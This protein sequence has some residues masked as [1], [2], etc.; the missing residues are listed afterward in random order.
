MRDKKLTVVIRGKLPSSKELLGFK[1]YFPSH[2]SARS[3]SDSFRCSCSLPTSLFHS[4]SQLSLSMLS[5]PWETRNGKTTAE[6]KGMDPRRRQKTQHLKTE[7]PN[8]SWRKIVQLGKLDRD[9]KSCSHRWRNYLHPDINKGEFSQEEDE[10]I[11]FLKGADVR[12]ASMPKYV[13]R[14][15]ANAI[16]NRWNNHLKKKNAT[17]D[18]LAYL[19]PNLD[20]NAIRLIAGPN[21]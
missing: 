6:E 10:L 12:W 11:I 18:D 21:S 14:R 17:I 16:K 20:P 3:P 15:S 4:F 2:E 1:L 9:E 7:Y 5:S 19:I 8:L 13:P